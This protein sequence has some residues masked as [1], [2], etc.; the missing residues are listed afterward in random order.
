MRQSKKLHSLL[1]PPPPIGGGLGW[2]WKTSPSVQNKTQNK[3]K[4]SGNVFIIILVAIALFGALMFTFARSGSQGI[5]SISKQEAKIAAQEI[6]NYAR[7]V[8]GAVDR[9]RRNGC[10]ESEISFENAVVAG[11]INPNSPP[12]KSCDIFD[13][14]GGK[15]TFNDVS[16]ITSNNSHWLLSPSIAIVNI[17]T[18]SAVNSCT[19]NSCT[20][21]SIFLG[22]IDT[23]L[24]SALNTLVNAPTASAENMAGYGGKFTG[25]FTNT[26]QLGD[27][28]T[29]YRNTP[30]ACLDGNSNPAGLYFYH[31]LLAR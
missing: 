24:C 1:P 25:D 6:L 7:L 27:A 2:G 31:V 8:E 23:N 17:G 28:T 22:P 9:V 11:Y 12:D 29:T 13:D 10:S 4:Q 30:T 19:Q 18:D 5:S 14:A 16:D 20:E 21:L 15:I 26:D 3:A